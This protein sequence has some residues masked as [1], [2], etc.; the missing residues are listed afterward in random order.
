MDGSTTHLSG[1]ICD[2]ALPEAS[3]LGT[4]GF[5]QRCAQI[6][7]YKAHRTRVSTSW[8]LQLSIHRRMDHRA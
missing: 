5:F 7:A 4:Q 6:A 2:T 3:S 1:L 8:S